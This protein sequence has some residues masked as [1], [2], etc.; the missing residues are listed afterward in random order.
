MLLKNC[1]IGYPFPYDKDF[2][3]KP[4]EPFQQKR[5]DPNPRESIFDSLAKFK[6][7]SESR[8]FKISTSETEITYEKDFPGLDPSELNVLS[9]KRS[10]TINT[11]YRGKKINLV[12]S[13]DDYD[14]TQARASLKNGVL[15]IVVPKAMSEK[16]KIEIET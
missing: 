5:I 3:I 1:I 8:E 4:W 7:E 11:N 9:D 12:L 13:S 14:Y 6:Q 10:I 15:K 2:Y 16:I